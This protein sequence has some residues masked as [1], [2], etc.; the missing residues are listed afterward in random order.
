MNY[1][2]D[3]HSFLWFL[4]GSSNLSEKAKDCILN[5]ENHC[6]V[7]I[8]SFWE[9]SIKISLS[10]LHLEVS[11]HEILSQDIFPTLEIKKSHLKELS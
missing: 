9:I 11:I 7:S 5:A 2:L 4:I 10:K 8:A 1:L 6:Y 3:T